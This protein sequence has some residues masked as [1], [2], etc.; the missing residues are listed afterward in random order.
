[1]AGDIVIKGQADVIGAL[2]AVGRAV[3][4]MTAVNGR[5]AARLLPDVRGGTPRR[6]GALAVSWGTGATADVASIGSPLRYAG[7]VEFGTSRFAGFRMVRDAIDRNEGDIVKG[8]ESAIADA[9]KRAGFRVT[10]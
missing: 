8:Y 2:D 1:M 6:T 4:D 3:D 7:P 10:Q 5:V 9:G